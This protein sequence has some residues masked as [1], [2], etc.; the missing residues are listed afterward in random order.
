MVLEVNPQ[1]VNRV[2]ISLR[3][4]ELAPDISGKPK[5]QKKKTLRSQ[6]LKKKNSISILYKGLIIW[7]KPKIDLRIYFFHKCVG[8]D[9]ENVKCFRFM[10]NDN[11]KVKIYEISDEWA[12]DVSEMYFKMLIPTGGEWI[13]VKGPPR[14]SLWILFSER[15]SF[16]PMLPETYENYITRTK[17]RS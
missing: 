17:K 5:K 1:I 15:E 8:G 6:N 9:F 13:K 7:A 16:K 14:G 12:H 3:K 4:N 10:R 2:L 11:W